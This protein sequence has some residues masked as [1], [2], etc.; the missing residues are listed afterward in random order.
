MNN[1]YWDLFN[2]INK[3]LLLSQISK[4][5]VAKE[6]NI[7]QTAFSNQL[8]NLKNG[9]GINITTIK[10]IEELTGEIFFLL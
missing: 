9:K 7:S 3:T 4:G 1:F 2:K 10:K 8:K 5:T 6:L